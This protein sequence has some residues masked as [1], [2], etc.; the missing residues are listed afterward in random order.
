MKRRRLYLR[1]QRKG[2]HYRILSIRQ[3]K[4]YSHP[5][6][7]RHRLHLLR[8]R[9]LSVTFLRFPTHLLFEKTLL[10]GVIPLSEITS[11][12]EKTVMF[13]TI[14]LCAATLLLG[15]MLP[16]AAIPLFGATLPSATKK[17]F[18][19][20]LISV[21]TVLCGMTVPPAMA[22]LLAMKLLP[23]TTK[24]LEKTVPGATPLLLSNNQLLFRNVKAA[25]AHRRYHTSLTSSSTS[26][27]LFSKSVKWPSRRTKNR[28]AK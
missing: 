9:L 21:M 5:R 28:H 27:A 4:P 10:F 8:L 6:P 11:L 13:V 16:S 22:L 3:R 1:R 14:V 18:E 2:K 20:R 23:T 7:R 17:P 19:K 25:L 26:F 24:L 15:T 12:V